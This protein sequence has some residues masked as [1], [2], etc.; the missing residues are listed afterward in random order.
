M[1]TRHV[2][3]RQPSR[4]VTEAAQGEQHVLWTS[5]NVPQLRAALNL[6]RT[7][8][9][10]DETLLDEVDLVLDELAYGELAEFSQGDV[11][12]LIATAA[13]NL[14]ALQEWEVDWDEDGE[15]A[16]AR[17]VAHADPRMVGRR[18]T[19]LWRPTPTLTR[20]YGVGRERRPRGAPRRRRARARSP[21][22]R[23]REPDPEPDDVAVRRLR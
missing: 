4:F 21:S 3:Q 8:G 15:L 23:A 2:R 13:T 6:A 1:P 5:D 20:L 19:R 14:F 10:V 17:C 9:T 7:C 22:G 16:Q 11:F 18:V 12:D